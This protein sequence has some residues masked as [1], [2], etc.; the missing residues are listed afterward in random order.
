MLRSDDSCMIVWIAMPALDRQKPKIATHG[1][2]IQRSLVA[3]TPIAAMAPATAVTAAMCT[4]A[5]ERLVSE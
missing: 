5:G 3:L 1:T 2:A 4:V